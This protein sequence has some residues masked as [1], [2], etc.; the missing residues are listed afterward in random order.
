MHKA[1]G[2]WMLEQN[3]RGSFLFPGAFGAG[4]DR[5]GTRAKQKALL[6]KLPATPALSAAP[7]LET[8]SLALPS[9]KHLTTTPQWNSLV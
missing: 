4:S 2:R 3:L 8:R 1:P 7:Q 6:K 5:K 9:E